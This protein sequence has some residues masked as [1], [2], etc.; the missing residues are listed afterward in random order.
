M[1]TD[2]KVHVGERDASSSK[3]VSGGVLE[4]ANPAHYPS[5]TSDGSPCAMSRLTESFK[6]RVL[7]DNVGVAVNGGPGASDSEV[8][9]TKPGQQSPTRSP[10]MSTGRSANKVVPEITSQSSD[11]T[12]PLQAAD[13]RQHAA[14]VCQV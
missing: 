6:D 3:A 14:Q 4:P 11:E 7:S 1:N 2:N 13:N 9:P 12:P 8:V 10:R 5:L